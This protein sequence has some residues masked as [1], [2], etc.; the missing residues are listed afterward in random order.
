M[1]QCSRALGDAA[2]VAAMA[3]ALATP[4]CEPGPGLAG[5]PAAL[6]SN[7]EPPSDEEPAHSA[8]GRLTPHEGIILPTM[9][10]HA[11][12][13]G[14]EDVDGA[15][16]EDAFIEWLLTSN[17]YWNLLAQYGVGYGVMEE[18]RRVSTASFFPE[19]A[20]TT[21]TI[22]ESALDAL[23]FA[24]TFAL[25]NEGDA[26]VVDAPLGRD[27]YVF[28]MPTTIQIGQEGELSCATFGGYH[29]TLGRSAIAP[30]Y[31]VIPTC[32]GL[33]LEMPISHELAEMA[34]DP[35]ANGWYSDV[36]VQNAGGEVADLCN[37]PVIEPVDLWSPTQLW[38]NVN[39]G[40]QP[41]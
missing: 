33:A 17:G 26:G 20:R 29:W 8:S 41:R 16:N 35:S 7:A 32:V 2:V 22:T 25:I 6:E 24:F 28:F 12:Y 1:P 10:V 36:D 11:I 3:A 13:I 14:A 4:H 30:P 31:A 5:I 40:C 18:S 34:T 19:S 21:A 15:P 23:I 38:S 9:H 37:A 39:G 27:A